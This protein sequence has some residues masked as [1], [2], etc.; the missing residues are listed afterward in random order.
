MLRNT[1]VVGKNLTRVFVYHMVATSL[2]Y[3][4]LAKIMACWLDI[5]G[6]I[7][8]TFLCGSFM[9]ESP[10]N[11]LLQIFFLTWMKTGF[12][13]FSPIKFLFVLYVSVYIFFHT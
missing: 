13:H 10:N 8:A 3:R 6:S 11:K 1:Q 12:S 5:H 7:N 2:P 4:F 9:Q